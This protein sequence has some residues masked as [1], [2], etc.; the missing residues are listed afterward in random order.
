MLISRVPTA[1]RTKD[2]PGD[3]LIIARC[4][5]TSVDVSSANYNRGAVTDCNAAPGMSAGIYF[6]RINGKLVAKGM[7]VSVEYRRSKD[8]EET[9]IGT[10]ALMFEQKFCDLAR[11]GLRFLAGGAARQRLRCEAIVALSPP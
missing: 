3:D 6:E 10:H 5:V 2:L 4:T 8:G 7:L 1:Y 9:V 11:G